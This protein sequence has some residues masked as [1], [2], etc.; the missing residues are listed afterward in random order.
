[1]RFAKPVIYI[2]LSCMLLAGAPELAQAKHTKSHAQKNMKHQ[3]KDRNDDGIITRTE[4][5]GEDDQSFNNQD[6]NGDG[7]LSGN[8][9]KPGAQRPVTHYDTFR[10]L[11]QNNNGYITRGE[12]RNTSG[13]FNELDLNSDGR[14]TRGEFFTRSIY[15]ASVFN[16]LDMNND[17]RISRGE[18]HDTSNVFSRLDANGDNLLSEAEFTGRQSQNPFV[19][20]FNKVF[21]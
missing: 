19:Q 14:L 1:M 17:L 10:T 15:T 16:K 21:H 8:E 7:I 12:W 20:L 3:G 5:R 4:W 2:S 9:L 13:S 6:W 11:D 18:W